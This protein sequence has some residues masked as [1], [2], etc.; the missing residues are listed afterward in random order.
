LDDEIISQSGMDGEFILL[1]VSGPATINFISSV[2]TL[3]S[4]KDYPFASS[5]KFNYI[6]YPGSFRATLVQTSNEMYRALMAAHTGMNRIQLNMKQLPSYI[7]TALKLILQGTPK[8]IKALLPLQLDNIERITHE[9]AVIANTT[10]GQFFDLIELLM[11]IE[12]LNT[13]T[14]SE[15]E[16]ENLRLRNETN[17]VR[18]SQMALEQHIKYTTEQYAK[19]TKE[20]EEKQKAYQEAVQ[21]SQRLS[22]I[23]S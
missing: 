6:K 20:L 16:K 10:H 7:K 18:E 8:L 11:E 17:T 19:I 4:K 12:K 23:Y 1:M 14:L 22:E 2:M 9:C 5:G 15:N 13:L 21:V 3:S